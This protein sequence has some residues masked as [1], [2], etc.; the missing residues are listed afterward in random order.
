MIELLYISR[1]LLQILK[2][3]W[4]TK[5]HVLTLHSSCDHNT[6]TYPTSSHQ[7]MNRKNLVTVTND[8]VKL[9]KLMEQYDKSPKRRKR[10][11]D[12]RK[13][14]LKLLKRTESKEKNF[15]V[16]SESSSSSEESLQW[17]E[18]EE[19]EEVADLLCWFLLFIDSFCFVFV[20]ASIFVII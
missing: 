18:E 7:N 20:F 13:P 15:F 4:I 5:R 2:P 10:Q 16:Y 19:E 12:W 14:G 9:H 8:V 17:E 1:T 6:S 11:S 3:M